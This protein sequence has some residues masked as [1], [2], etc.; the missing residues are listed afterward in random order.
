MKRVGK[1]TCGNRYCSP[2]LR[3]ETRRRKAEEAMAGPADDAE[4]LALRCCVCGTSVD[5]DSNYLNT[6]MK[7][8]ISKCGHRLYVPRAFAGA[9]RGD[10]SPS[11]GRSLGLVMP[12]RRAADAAGRRRTQLRP[13][14]QAR[15]PAPARDPVPRVPEARQEVAAAGQ[16]DRGAQLRQGDVSAQEGH[17]GVRRPA[18]W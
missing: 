7:M 17:E 16:D 4:D 9:E 3:G 8:L 2:F 13:L 14:H 10:R 15:V 1:W 5:D 6:K 11:V 18:R 12:E